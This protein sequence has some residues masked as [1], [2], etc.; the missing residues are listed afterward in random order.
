ML[1]R[2]SFL[3]ERYKYILLR[4]QTLNE[5]TFKIAAIY[6]VIIITLAAAQYNIINLLNTYK[7]DKIKAIFFSNC[8]MAMLLILT[9]FTVTLLIGGVFS[10]LKYRNEESDIEQEAFG[11]SRKKP[12]L[13]NVVRWYET[14]LVLT[15]LLIFIASSTTYVKI[16]YPMLNL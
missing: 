10:W 15:I 16:V 3:L 5:A 4:K 8:L 2:E 7:I 13:T 14:Y 12:K 9:I 11:L 1:N 6:Q